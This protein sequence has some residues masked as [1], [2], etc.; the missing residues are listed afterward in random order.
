MTWLGRVLPVASLLLAL[1]SFYLS[2]SA[3]KEVARLDT[4][5]TTYTLFAD[6]GRVQLEHPLMAHLFAVTGESY[7]TSVAEVR[8]ATSTASDQERARLRL[9]ERALAHH[10]FTAYEETYFLWREAKDGERG[11][12]DILYGDL[13]FLNS[14]LCDNPRLL[15]YWDTK[16]GAKLGQ[17]FAAEVRNY[18]GVNVLRECPTRGDPDGPFNPRRA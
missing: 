17:V 1:V 6:L 13:T 8:A 12:R 14:L 2:A 18:Y 15:W 11:R 4:I 5:K 9:Q 7:D 16:G 10:I 3:Q